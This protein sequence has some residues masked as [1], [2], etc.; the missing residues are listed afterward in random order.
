[1]M[2]RNMNKE[3]IVGLII[4]FVFKILVSKLNMIW[5]VAKN[6]GNL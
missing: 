6:C 3:G 2:I 4:A 1:M 5:I